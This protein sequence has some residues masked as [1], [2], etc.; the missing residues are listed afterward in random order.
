MKDVLLVPQKSTFEIQDFTYVYI[1]DEK[2]MVSIRSF[3]PISR[4][5]SFYVTDDLPTNTRMV[6]EGVQ[7]VK[8]GA[9]IVPE[10]VD[11]DAILEEDKVKFNY[12]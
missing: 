3:T 4:F 9:Q 7:L 11:I 12:N 6:Y 1:V 5:G 10:M 2:G 8:D